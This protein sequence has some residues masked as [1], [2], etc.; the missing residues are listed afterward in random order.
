MGL[1]GTPVVCI[2]QTMQKNRKILQP[3]MQTEGCLFDVW[4]NDQGKGFLY[5]Y[6]KA[7]LCA[8]L[9]KCIL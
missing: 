4:C 9:V 5:Y 3:V 8:V 7:A 2:N 6:L 1:P